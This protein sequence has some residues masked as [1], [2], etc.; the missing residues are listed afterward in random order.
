MVIVERY[1]I[2]QAVMELT[3]ASWGMDVHTIGK[4]SC[5]ITQEL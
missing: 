5:S 3:V 4:L 1:Q 2:R